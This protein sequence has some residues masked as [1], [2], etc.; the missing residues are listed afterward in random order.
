MKGKEPKVDRIRIQ[1]LVERI[2][3]VGV[4]GSDRTNVHGDVPDTYGVMFEC[5]GVI[6]WAI[7]RLIPELWHHE[8][9]V[10]ELFHVPICPSVHHGDRTR[11]A[12]DTV[13]ADRAEDQARDLSPST[14]AHDEQ[15]RV[16]APCHQDLRRVA[17]VTFALGYDRRFAGGDL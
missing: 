3:T 15:Y 13:F 4:V 8:P 12:V 7:G 11:G 17:V 14:R 6:R 9:G 5:P 2:E 16:L 1:M 10:V